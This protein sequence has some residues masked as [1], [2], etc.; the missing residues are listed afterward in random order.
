MRCHNNGYQTYGYDVNKYSPH[1]DKSIVA[2][3]YDAVTLW[4]VLEHMEDPAGFASALN[5][6]FLFVLTPDASGLK[7]KFDGWRH[8]RPDEH[9]HYFTK[10]SMTRFMERSGFKVREMNHDEGK[11]R[12]PKHPGW[13]VTCVGERRY[14]YSR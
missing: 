6:R 3:G 8:Y 7:G 1:K 11:L 4:D 14:R 13:L 5:T 12:D 2:Y 9:Q 10:E